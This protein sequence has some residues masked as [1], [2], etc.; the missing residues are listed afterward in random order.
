M[1]SMRSTL[2]GLRCCKF[3]SA[4]PAALTLRSRRSDVEA[5]R[6]VPRFPIS[7]FAFT[8]DFDYVELLKDSSEVVSDSRHVEDALAHIQNIRVH[9][10]RDL[11]CTLACASLRLLN[12]PKAW[13]TWLM[14]A[15]A[16]AP[17]N[18]LEEEQ[19]AARLRQFWLIL[20][21][22]HA[23]GVAALKVASSIY[24]DCLLIGLTTAAERLAQLI[25]TLTTTFLTFS[26][27][28]LVPQAVVQRWHE[29]GSLSPSST[30]LEKSTFQTR[31]VIRA[32]A[33]SNP[34]SSSTSSLRTS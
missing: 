23:G 14:F 13:L 22:C 19:K 2:T 4:D 20:R 34:V 25:I 24:K 3:P 30:L 5:Q 29:A 12:C 27:T 7:D 8:F 28:Q 16:A 26:L 6:L 11:S 33:A 15:I 18:L 1:P 32:M 17:S 9:V 21:Q 31:K 10:V